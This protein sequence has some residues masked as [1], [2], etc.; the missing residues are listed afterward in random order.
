M[1]QLTNLFQ[2]HKTVKFEL[3]PIGRTD[4][5]ISSDGFLASDDKDK[6]MAYQVVKCLIVNYYQNEVIAPLLEK[7]KD[8]K[9][10]N[11]LLVAYGNATDSNTRRTI[12]KKL[13]GIIDQ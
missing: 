10:W 8:N 9:E 7:I 5:L 4:E 3:R 13:A 2:V 6:A 11:R 12:S 1:E